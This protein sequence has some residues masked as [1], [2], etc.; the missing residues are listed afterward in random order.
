VTNPD[1]SSAPGLLDLNAL[2]KSQGFELR[3]ADPAKLEQEKAEDRHRRLLELLR[4]CF[5]APSLVGTGI[6]LAW[7]VQRTPARPDLQSP[8]L[9][10]LLAL[11]S[12]CGG[13]LSGRASMK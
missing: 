12:A 5:F 13:F 8:A 11:V 1:S 9:A 10:G 6:F 3:I 4:F 7:L 2:V